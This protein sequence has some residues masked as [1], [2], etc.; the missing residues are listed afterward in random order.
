MKHGGLRKFSVAQTLSRNGLISAGKRMRHV[1]YLWCKIQLGAPSQCPVVAGQHL[2]DLAFLNFASQMP[3]LP[4]LSPSPGF[5]RK[6]FS[7]WLTTNNKWDHSALKHS[8]A[9]DG[10]THTFASYDDC[11]LDLV[12]IL[13]K[14]VQ[15][16]RLLPIESQRVNIR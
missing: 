12:V 2:C 14:L 15:L 7:P 13:H 4:H 16:N 8:D 11:N 10:G 1:R 6:T 9:E 5:N 3:C